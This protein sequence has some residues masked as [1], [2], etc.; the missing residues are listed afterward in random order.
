M[1]SPEGMIKKAACLKRGTAYSKQRIVRGER[2]AFI[3]RAG[4]AEPFARS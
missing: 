3:L 4:I 1:Y 2:I